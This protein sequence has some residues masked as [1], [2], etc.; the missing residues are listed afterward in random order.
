MPEDNTTPQATGGTGIAG[1]K[2]WYIIGG[3][4][5]I[6]ILGWIF[7]GRFARNAAERAIEKATGG[8]VEYNR[9]GTATYKT[10]E[11]TVTV[12]GGSYPDTWPSD[13][14]KYPGAEITYSGSSN[15]Q[16]GAAGAALVLTTSDSPSAVIE[17][18]KRE[19]TSRGW[20]IESTASVAGATII[21][22]TK[23][24][25]TFGVWAADAG[26]TTQVTVSV[27]M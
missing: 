13:G 14:P 23:D 26:G 1:K 6:I 27:E 24:G 18:Y 12:G 10:D 9:D 3:I 5:V 17:Y 20:K 25:R 16:T 11:G 15:P 7:S 2:L 4:V 22:A 21:S 19:L 8:D